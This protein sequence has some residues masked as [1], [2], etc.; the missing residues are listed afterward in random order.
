MRAITLGLFDRMAEISWY[1]FDLYQTALDRLAAAKAAA[2][3]RLAWWTGYLSSG[4]LKYHQQLDPFMWPRTTARIVKGAE[5]EA[6]R[7]RRDRIIGE[8]SKVLGGEIIRGADY[9][10][11]AP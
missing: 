5:L 6:L 2:E 8:A 9:G 4:G 3:R 11:D 7:A 1:E 10:K